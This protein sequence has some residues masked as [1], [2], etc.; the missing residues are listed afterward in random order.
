[1]RI[2]NTQE[3]VKMK[4]AARLSTQILEELAK[5]LVPGRTPGDID[6]KAWEL[7]KE[8]GVVPSFYN[9]KGH[10]GIYGYSCCVSV[11][12]EVLHGIPDDDYH[13]QT[14]DVAKIDFGIVKDGYYTDQCFTFGVGSLSEEDKRLV[15]ISRMA[16]ETA[17]K[18]ALDG[19]RAGDLGFTM[20]GIARAAGYDTLKMFVGHGLGKSLHEP[21]EIPTFGPA[22]V[23]DKL[24]FGMVISVECQ[25]IPFEDEVYVDDDGWTIKTANG[26][27]GAMFEYM[28]I[29]GDEEA[30]ILTPMQDWDIIISV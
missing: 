27:R 25:L 29:V 7:T 20:E 28:V 22:G 30:E 23:G 13:F 15:N 6:R 4:E 14:G 21:P 2:K 26:G 3:E 12:D 10:R 16:T 17:M 8:A 24:K 11:N 1:M 9:V 19:V 18:K 5:E